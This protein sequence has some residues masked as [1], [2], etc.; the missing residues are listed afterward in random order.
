MKTKLIF[1]ILIMILLV[2]GQGCERTVDDFSPPTDEE[3]KSIFT[4]QAKEIK[5]LEL[6]I[7]VYKQ[8]NE[9]LEKIKKI[10]EGLLEEEKTID[11]DEELRNLNL[12]IPCPEGMYWVALTADDKTIRYQCVRENF[13]E[14]NLKLNIFF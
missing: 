5:E 12:E 1:G 3:V 6:R 2:S 13:E 7:E 4:E 10:F 8:R 14:Q 9:D 11:V